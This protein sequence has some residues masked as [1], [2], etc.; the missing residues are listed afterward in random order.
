MTVEVLCL[1]NLEQRLKK[2]IPNSTLSILATPGN[3][4]SLIPTPRFDQLI[5]TNDE[6]IFEE[7]KICTVNSDSS[8]KTRDEG[9]GTGGQ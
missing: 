8:G 6:V 1:K 7:I 4:Q 2:T 9:T 5:S 3:I